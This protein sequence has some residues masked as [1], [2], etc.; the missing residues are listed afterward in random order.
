MLNGPQR[1]ALFV[2]AKKLMV[3]YVPYK[4]TVHRISTDMWHPWVVGF[5]RPVFNNEWWHMIDLD[6]GLRPAIE[7]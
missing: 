4:A 6:L 1:D 7:A 2:E 3:A 5:R